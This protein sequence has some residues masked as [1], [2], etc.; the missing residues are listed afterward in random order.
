MIVHEAGTI[1]DADAHETVSMAVVAA[2]AVAEGVSE[3]ELQPLYDAGIDPDALNQLF[4]ETR[5]SVQGFL[6][7]SYLGYVVAVTSD[8]SVSV[9]RPTLD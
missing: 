8:G 9:E 5:A 3:T 6:S 2:V 1:T 7:F 4:D